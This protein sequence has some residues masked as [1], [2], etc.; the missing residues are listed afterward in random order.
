MTDVMDGMIFFH[1][2]TRASR[3]ASLAVGLLEVEGRFRAAQDQ[4]NSHKR[5]TLALDI[6]NTPNMNSDDHFVQLRAAI[7][8][9]MPFWTGQEQIA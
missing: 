9:S 1:A 2:G 7:W 4:S 5:A 6:S 8:K 3:F